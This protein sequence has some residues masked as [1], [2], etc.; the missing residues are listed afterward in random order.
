M[1]VKMIFLEAPVLS[2]VSAID[3][4]TAK[5]Q[6]NMVTKISALEDELA[7]LRTQ[8]A[9]LVTSQ[10]NNG[11]LVATEVLSDYLKLFVNYSVCG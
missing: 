10:H 2:S 5:P 7:S 3:V 8:I 4:G 9:A 6:V 11:E 1:K